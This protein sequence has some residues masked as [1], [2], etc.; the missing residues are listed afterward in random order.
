MLR[1][2]LARSGHANAP[3][4]A[5]NTT[6]SQRYHRRLLSKL[7]T[8]TPHQVAPVRRSSQRLDLVSSEHPVL[9][10]MRFPALCR[11]GVHLTIAL[12]RGRVRQMA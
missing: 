10:R 8:A 4:V 9:G 7:A 5:F 6:S 12:L 11:L 1:F 3:L 2:T